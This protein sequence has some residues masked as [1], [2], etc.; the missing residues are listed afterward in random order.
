MSAPV[1]FVISSLTLDTVTW[2]AVT[3]PFA[4]NTIVIKNADPA[5]AIKLRTDSAVATTEDTIPVGS[6]EVIPI[7]PR[8]QHLGAPGFD[9]WSWFV[10]GTNYAYLQASAGTGPAFNGDLGYPVVLDTNVHTYEIYWTNSSAWFFMDN[11]FL[12]KMSATTTPLAGT[13]HLK[14]SAS[15]ADS[16]GNNAINSIIVRVSSIVRL[17]Q[18]DT[19]SNYRNLTTAATTV[20][21][22]GPG[23]LHRV[24][25][26]DGPPGSSIVIYDNTAG[27]GTIISTINT[28]TIASPLSMEFGC[29]FSTGLTCVMTGNVNVTFIYE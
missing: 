1:P 9:G 5:N 8:P 12:H 20:L 18:L 16:G 3:P 28:A 23:R 25:I 14:V 15:S 17:G 26:N 10:P 2:T 24:I 22:Y 19:E 4:C 7:P 21:K 27:S 11:E 13:P 6:Q 29:P